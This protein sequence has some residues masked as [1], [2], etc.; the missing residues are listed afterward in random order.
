[1]L[2]GGAAGT[3]QITKTG[4]GIPTVF[5][6]DGIP[7]STAI[8]DMWVDTND[9]NKTY[10]AKSVGANEISA[11]EWVVI[12]AGTD[13]ANIG[14]SNVANETRATILGGNLTGTVNSVAVA[15]VSSGAASGATANQDSTSSIRAGTTAAN[16]G[17]GNVANETRA[18]ILGGNLTGTVNSIAVATVSSGAAAGATANQDSTST[19]LGGELTGTLQTAAFPMK[20]MVTG[21][22]AAAV[23]TTIA[24]NNVDNSSAA[25][26][27]AGTTKANVGLSNV[28]NE[29]RATILAG[30]ITGTVNSVAV[31]TVT[32]GAALGTSSNQDSTSSIRAGTTKANV[33]LSN[34]ANETRATILGGELTGTLQTTAF[35]MKAMVTGANAAAVKTTIAL[36]NVANENRATI[37]GGNLTGTVNS[38]A[39]ATVT[40]KVS[41]LN[42]DGDIDDAITIVNG[43]TIEAGTDSNN[44]ITIDGTNKRIDILD[45]GT[46]RVRIGQL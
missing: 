8:G 43:G 33:G 9:G 29:T 42:V 21:A 46:V 40:G 24:L 17:L 41:N 13:K 23:K 28:A 5:S 31:A 14:L 38:V 37:L 6:Q 2:A 10:R 7:T 36:N 34:V 11:T 15:T 27:Q 3:Q 4:V 25:T 22:N 32:S 12:G 35:P 45:S 39:A 19:I 26:I 44:K 30:N 16:V 18:T 1:V 20:A